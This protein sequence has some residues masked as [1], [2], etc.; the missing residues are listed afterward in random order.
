MELC[1]QAASGDCDARRLAMELDESLAVL[2]K[3]DEGPDLVLFYKHLMVLEG[4]P[5]YEHHFNRSD[6]LS[7]SQRAFLEDQ[8]RTFR[9]WWDA[10][11]GKAA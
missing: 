2:S 9:N 3:Y 8:W 6:A 4:S 1:Q 5:E 7:T 10:W 11:P